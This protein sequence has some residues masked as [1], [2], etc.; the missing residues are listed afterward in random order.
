VTHL[1]VFITHLHV[2]ERVRIKSL[3]TKMYKICIIFKIIQK[4]SNYNFLKIQKNDLKLIFFRE[5]YSLNSSSYIYRIY[6]YIIIYCSLILILK[7]INFCMAIWVTSMYFCLRKRLICASMQ[8]NSITVKL[9][10]T[11][12]SNIS[13]FAFLNI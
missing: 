2:Q 10:I 1:Q 7:E 4:H 3:Y 8:C 6:M 5:I 11:F 12:F 9:N 13:F